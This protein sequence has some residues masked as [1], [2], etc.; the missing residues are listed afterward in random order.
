MI[1]S[2]SS[3]K[4]KIAIIPLVFFLLSLGGTI[5]IFLTLAEQTNDSLVVNIAG[6]QRMLN[7]RY[8]K[9]V[10]LTRNGQNEDYHKT[11]NL[12]YKSLMA[13]DKGG[14][15]VGGNGKSVVVLPTAPTVELANLLEKNKLLMD[16]QKE[17]VDKLMQVTD[18]DLLASLLK[19]NKR[20]HQGANEAVTL[21]QIVSQNKIANLKKMLLG[22]VALNLF[23][24]LIIFFVFIPS[25]IFKPFSKI[26]IKVG[27]LIDSIV[28]GNGNLVLSFEVNSRDEIG[29]LAEKMNELISSL[30][31]VILRVK[32]NS[33]FVSNAS[34]ELLTN[35]ESLIKMNSHLAEESGSIS[36]AIT[37]MSQT[38]QSIASAIEEMSISIAT[39]SKKAQD[40][41]QLT[42]EAEGSAK[43]ATDIA[44]DLGKSTTAIVKIV[45]VIANIA[46][47]I[48]L[49]SLNA[50]I[51]AAGAG[52]AGK[53]FSVVAQEIKELAEQTSKSSQDIVE[54]V[55]NINTQGKKTV[56]AMDNIGNF[57]VSISATNS[58]FASSVEEQSL[59]SREIS[60]SVE[61]STIAS[62]E[63]A[64]NNERINASFQNGL[65][66]A[67]NIGELSKQ[68]D[69]SS[70]ALEEVIAGFKV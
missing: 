29:R 10:L 52:D 69:N 33:N 3:L 36:T 43:I 31:D 48:N 22:V 46:S 57:I 2:N 41:S 15:T 26:M 6:R 40:A 60:S 53:G 44:D 68:L 7:Q 54:M 70:E 27:V 61:Q 24:A 1:L 51:E 23:L 21:F 19:I 62:N 67:D 5:Y 66:M 58:S 14:E 17:L 28:S 47:Q 56:D 25:I 16:K 49:L 35:G 55:A 59:A 20:V 11:L 42:A 4:V 34:G 37:E 18:N 8:L 39:M 12:F 30:R 13:L 50:A 65:S 38:Q 9:Q 63:I 45:D 32:E 64:A